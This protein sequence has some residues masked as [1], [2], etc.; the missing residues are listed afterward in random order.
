M[1]SR[2]SVLVGCPVCH[3]RM[4][5]EESQIGQEVICPDCG[6]PTTVSRPAENR[7]KSH[8]RRPK[9]SATTPWLRRLAGGG[10]VPAA[11]QSYVAVVCPV[12]HTR[13]HATADQVGNRIHLPHCG[14]PAVV[15]PMPRRGRR[16]T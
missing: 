2:A 11:E 14:S 10:A 3:A 8:D 16:S 4:H 13:M 9:R 5:P 12:C 15:S 7:R 1:N 6:T